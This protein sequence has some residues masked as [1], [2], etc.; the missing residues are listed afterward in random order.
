MLRHPGRNH[1]RTGTMPHSRSPVVSGRSV[2]PPTRL[3]GRV[4][5]RPPRQAADADASLSSAP[6]AREATPAPQPTVTGPART[7][8]EHHDPTPAAGGQVLRTASPRLS[9]P[10]KEKRRRG[11][12]GFSITPHHH[13]TPSFFRVALTDHTEGKSFGIRE[14]ARAARRERQASPAADERARQLR[15]KCG[16]ATA[17]PRRN[18]HREPTCR[19]AAVRTRPAVRTGPDDWAWSP[20]VADTRFVLSLSCRWTSPGR[21]RAGWGLRVWGLARA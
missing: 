5:G 10:R 4:G 18:P 3:C 16:S 20:A 14:S 9:V 15:V 1:A 13:Q 8:A 21:T 2:R 17:K 11:G 6:P 7:A 19:A 12:V